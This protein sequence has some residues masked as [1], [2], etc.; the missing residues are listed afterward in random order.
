[1]TELIT[2]S[3]GNLAEE[4]ITAKWSNTYDIEM[5]NNAN[6]TIWGSSDTNYL[7]LGGTGEVSKVG[8][9]LQFKVKDN[10]EYRYPFMSSYMNNTYLSFYKGD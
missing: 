5:T 10:E 9:S 7:G 3:Y 8:N 1:M 2:G 4:L 6:T